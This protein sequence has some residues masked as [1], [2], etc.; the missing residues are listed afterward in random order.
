M[1]HRDTKAS[2]ALLGVLVLGVAG[3]G[4][5]VANVTGTASRA[6]GSPLAD[7]RVMARSANGKWFSGVTDAAGQ[8]ELGSP[9]T[10]PG[11]PAGE[12]QVSLVE[13]RGGME[14]MKPPQFPAR[15]ANPSESLLSIKVAAGESKVFDIQVT[16]N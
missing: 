6:D 7:V 2:G 8:Y 4:G 9:E 16:A 5:D 15:Y 3:C 12:Y 14:S 13:D 10:G 1:T 11:V